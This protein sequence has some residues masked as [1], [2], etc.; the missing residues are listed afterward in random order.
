MTPEDRSKQRFEGLLGVVERNSGRVDD[1]QGE[2]TLAQARLIV[3]PAGKELSLC[4]TIEQWAPRLK[5][6]GQA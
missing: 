6:S 2:P 5:L 3:R 4:H 1:D